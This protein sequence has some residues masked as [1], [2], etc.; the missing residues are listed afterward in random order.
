[1]ANIIGLKREIF[2]VEI[3]NIKRC[4]KLNLNRKLAIE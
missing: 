4:A 2:S 3:R 1:M